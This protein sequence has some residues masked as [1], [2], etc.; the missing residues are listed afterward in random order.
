MPE[1][2]IQIVYEMQYH[3]RLGNAADINLPQLNNNN[4]FTRTFDNDASFVRYIYVLC[5]EIKEAYEILL[6]INTAAVI[7]GLWDE[8]EIDLEGD[9]DEDDLFIGDYTYPVVFYEIGLGLGLGLEATIT[10]TDEI[11]QYGQA[12]AGEVRETNEQRWIRE[13]YA[14]AG[15]VREQQAAE[16]HFYD[17]PDSVPDGIIPRVVAVGRTFDLEHFRNL[18]P[19]R[20]ERK[21]FYDDFDLPADQV[22]CDFQQGHKEYPVMAIPYDENIEQKVYCV[23][24]I[25]QWV[26]TRNSNGTMKN[27]DPFTRGIIKDIRIM[28]EGDIEKKELE[29]FTKGKGKKRIR[30]LERKILDRKKEKIRR[31]TLN[32]LLELK[33]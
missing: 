33:F 15:E 18:G 29:E 19:F 23:T 21:L 3:V 31:K 22:D 13:D 11:D 1:Y 27:T 10:L 20:I 9:G 7:N 14:R 5:E 8:Y 30:D 16:S 26:L 28:D 32:R 17:N 24:E 25:L 6:N 2:T 12:Q 4:Q